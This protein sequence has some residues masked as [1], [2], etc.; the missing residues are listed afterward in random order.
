MNRIFFAGYVGEG[1]KCMLE[2]VSDLENV[3]LIDN[4]F[5]NK[6]IRYIYY[7]LIRNK[8]NPFLLRLLFPFFSLTRQLTVSDEGVIIYFNS[9]FK[10]EYNGEYVTRLKKK[11]PGYRHVLYIVDPTAIFSYEENR[12]IIDSMDLVYCINEKDSKEKGCF[13]FPLIYS[14]NNT[15]QAVSLGKE[16]SYDLYYLGSGDDR[17][18]ILR[19]ISEVCNSSGIESNLIVLSGFNKKEDGIIFIKDS[20]KSDENIQNIVKADCILELMHDGF[21]NPTQ[22]Y[23]EAVAY[24]KKLLT[25]NPNIINFEFYNSEFMK[26][27]NDVDD[28]IVSFIKAKKTIDYGYNGEF[29]PIKFVDRIV[30]DIR[31]LGL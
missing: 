1:A 6:A 5:N 16:E 23:A 30:A 22:R 25:N 19:R 9:G 15:E 20:I 27:F 3:T 31:R 4:V 2:D 28:G 24:N 29:S 26:V 11:Y 17:T 18:Q 7:N 13:Y 21:V 8:R 14:K 12:D 10:T